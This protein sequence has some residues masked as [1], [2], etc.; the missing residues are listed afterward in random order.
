M[1]SVSIG[2]RVVSPSK[3]I[4]DDERRRGFTLI[5]ALVALSLVLVFAST[6]GPFMFQSRRILVQGDGQVRA[7]LLLRSLLDTPFDR[8]SPKTGAS[9]GESGGLR[10]RL[11]VEPMGAALS[12][13]APRADAKKKDE[14]D[15]ALFRVIAHVAWG[16]GQT[17]TAETL[18]LG[19]IE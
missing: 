17:V 2:I 9:W 13:D 8:I 10:W 19:A 15:W 1:R 14:H 12:S 6:L 11:D 18:R 4:E 5:E 3:R 16:T 7:E